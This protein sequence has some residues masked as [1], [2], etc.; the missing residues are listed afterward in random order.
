MGQDKSAKPTAVD[1]VEHSHPRLPRRPFDQ[2]RESIRMA[3][4]VIVAGAGAR[5]N[6]WLR[7]VQADPDCRIV[8]C[9]DVDAKAREQAG[10]KWSIPTQSCFA[11]LD[12]AIEQVECEAV[13]IATP[14]EHHARNCE[15]AISF[16]RAVLVEKPFTL[17]LK[18]AIRIVELAEQAHT[19]LVV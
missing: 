12:Q 3:I 8:A 18:D 16:G 19:P 7:E 17:N 11:N 13:I 2:R 6:D 1:A 4:R 5:G 10:A 15:S 9:A 14:P